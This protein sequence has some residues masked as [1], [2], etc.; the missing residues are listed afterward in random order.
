MCSVYNSDIEQVRSAIMGDPGTIVSLLISR[1]TNL[2]ANQTASEQPAPPVLLASGQDNT[3]RSEGLEKTPNFECGYCGQCFSNQAFAQ[4]HAEFCRS[5]Q[6]ILMA[7]PAGVPHH[8][9]PPQEGV[10]QAN[11]SPLQ[12]FSTPRQP[13]P[14]PPSSQSP[15]ERIIAALREGLPPGWCDMFATMFQLQRECIRL[16][17]SFAC[18]SALLQL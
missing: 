11:A 1:H 7:T 14:Y 17:R 18:S 15:S 12:S 9:G 13:L 16:H 5:A 4:R 2:S 8:S 6:S 10:L 3:Q